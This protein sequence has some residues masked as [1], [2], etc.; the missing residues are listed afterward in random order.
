MSL[1]NHSCADEAGITVD[2]TK[3]K[4]W[5]VVASKRRPPLRRDEPI[6]RAAPET[7]SVQQED[8]APATGQGVTMPP[9]TFNVSPE[10]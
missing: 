5:P 2:G 4:H 1:F 6:G 9:F 10:T 8:G 3:R 7:Q